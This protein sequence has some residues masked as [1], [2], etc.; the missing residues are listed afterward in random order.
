MPK[1]SI[2]KPAVPLVKISHLWIKLGDGTRLSAK[3]W[4]S[5]AAPAPALV[6]IS[7][8]RKSD[9]SVTRD[10]GHCAALAAAGYGVLRIDQRG[11]GDSEGNFSG[12]FDR[13]DETDALQVLN[14]IAE[15]SWCD[16]KLGLF[17][18]SAG[19]TAALQIARRQPVGLG[20]IIA[21]AATDD[22]YEDDGIYHGGVPRS[23]LL[24]SATRQLAK[25][26][27]PQDVKLSGKAHQ[28]NWQAR[29]KHQRF[30]ATHWLQ[31]PQ[32]DDDWKAISA[33]EDIGLITAPVLLVAGW[34]DPA[35]GASLRLLQN[36]RSPCKAVIGAWGHEWP[37]E[38]A[39][40]QAIDFTVEMLRWFDHHFKGQATGVMQEPAIR[41][42]MADAAKAG[43]T[44]SGRWLS[45]M[46]WGPGASVSQ[47]LYLTGYGL[48]ASKGEERAFT[49]SSP[50][51]SGFGLASR[52]VDGAARDD[53]A[54]LTFDSPPL[55]AELDLAGAPTVAFDISADAEVAQVALRLSAISPTGEISVL[56]EKIQNLTQR[57]SR[58]HPT[59]LES[60]RRMGVTVKLSDM[61]CRLPKGFKLRVSIATSNFPSAWPAP[62]KVALTIYAGA[63]ELSLPIRQDRGMQKLVT[64]APA[65]RQPIGAQ[66]KRSFALDAVS[67]AAKL[68]VGDEVQKQNFFVKPDDVVSAKQQAEASYALGKFKTVVQSSLSATAKHWLLTAKL[69]AFE[70]KKRVYAKEFKEKI[71]RKLV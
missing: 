45:D 35:A 70:G 27:L 65:L 68:S 58:G 55:A 33:A 5:K 16:G 2:K 69:E 23:E 17:G 51:T 60:G 43:N 63:A 61:A 57:V 62:S 18:F 6:E 38:N 42:F 8:H 66:Q 3:L 52:Q 13:Q 71:A 24:A 39:D 25:S 15:Q 29:L 53:S 14:F 47:T 19:G 21:V 49:L 34:Q 26:S 59:A 46:A 44:I 64:F 48:S 22:P 50:L 56:S 9:L 67:G 7:P 28:K 1:K 54:A 12:S 41:F 36:L 20:A 40:G 32:R 4:L 10:A 31:H 30:M 37:Q 11:T